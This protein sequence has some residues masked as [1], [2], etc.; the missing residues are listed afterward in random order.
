[1]APSQFDVYYR[2]RRTGAVTHKPQ[3]EKIQ[4]LDSSQFDV[5]YCDRRTGHVTYEPRNDNSMDMDTSQPHNQAKGRRNRMKGVNKALNRVDIT[6]STGSRR[7]QFGKRPLHSRTGANAIKLPS[8]RMDLSSV[9]PLG[10]MTAASS[11]ADLAQLGQ[12]S[13]PME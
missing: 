12:R 7:R 9:P 6:H 3:K 4:N 2:D 13:L 5:F 10:A 11:P 8:E 1:M